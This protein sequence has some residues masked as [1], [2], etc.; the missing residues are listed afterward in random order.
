MRGRS[1]L[2]VVPKLPTWVVGVT[3]FVTAL[4]GLV[5]RWRGGPTVVTAVLVATGVAGCLL[6]C[7][8]VAFKRS[9]PLVGARGP[10]Q[11]PRARPWAL[12]GLAV[13]A[14]IALGA[15]GSYVVNRYLS[16]QKVIIL[17]ADF[18]GERP[19]DYSVTHQ[20]LDKLRAAMEP[21]RDEVKILALDDVITTQG[22]P[23][24]ARAKGSEKGA[25]VVLWG[26]YAVT[27]TTVRITV[28]FELLRPTP[29]FSPN[30]PTQVVTAT[31]DA[32]DGFTLQT[33]LSGQMSYLTLLSLG[34]ARLDARRY[35][36]AIDA[37]TDALT[38]GRAP[39]DIVD[40]GEIYVLRGTAYLA[41]G[42]FDRAL[43]DMNRAV[44]HGSDRT[45]SHVARGLLYLS[46]LDHD[47]GFKDLTTAIESAPPRDTTGNVKTRSKLAAAHWGR[48]M[49]Y[50]MKKVQAMPDR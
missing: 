36:K 18:D 27:R 43:A 20:I 31:P 38:Q 14:A 16:P 19:R 25:S 12:A 48:G 35:D 5:E 3:S 44:Q 46:R 21:Y 34:A 49:A 42:D 7:V 45:A 6:G 22:G 4:V 33:D 17:V 23:D 28:H 10:W 37:F 39:E 1:W 26:R 9:P 13:L 8:Y 29:A 2:D 11:Y 47:A 50:R 41:Q 15:S 24:L 32:L 30:Q 40:P